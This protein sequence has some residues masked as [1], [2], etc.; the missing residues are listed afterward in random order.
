[1]SLRAHAL[2]FAAT[3]L[4]PLPATRC[5]QPWLLG[6][7]GDTPAGMLPGPQHGPAGPI[8]T[9]SLYPGTRLGLS[10]EPVGGSSHPTTAMILDIAL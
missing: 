1:M 4:A 5:Y 9:T 8:T 2:V 6:P 3:G 10:I 7:H